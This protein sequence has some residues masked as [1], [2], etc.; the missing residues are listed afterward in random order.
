MALPLN[1]DTITVTGRFVNF[2]GVPIVGQVKFITNQMLIDATADT[3][4]V[5]SIVSV[6]LDGDGEFS[7]VLPVSDDP[8]IRP[9][10]FAYRVEEAFIG[11]RSYEVTLLTSL[12]STVDLADLR[13]P[14]VVTTIY[15]DAV[16]AGNW[17]TLVPRV[18]AAETYINNGV[19]AP[20]NYQNLA[21]RY[22]VYD[23][24]GVFDY[25][26]FDADG[27]LVFTESDVQ[28][29]IDQILG[30]AD[31]TA[32]N[33]ELRDT[34]DLGIVQS[35]TYAAHMLRHGTYDGLASAYSTYADPSTITWAYSEIG[36]L[37]EDLRK[38]M[39]GETTMVNP[40]LSHTITKTDSSYG[41]I[42]LSYDDYDALAAA[43]PDY[44]GPTG[45][46]FTFTY[47]DV[48]DKIR[49]EANRINR[50]MLLGVGG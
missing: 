22:L 28:V 21:L 19:V 14:D 34:T 31:Y 13:P 39:A 40:Y 3:H 6:T 20:Y 49:A 12:G 1:L 9:E 10:L 2:A 46:S 23:N 26:D 25:E 15:E 16:S 27:T 48:A 45:D 30:L 24:L 11:G 37:I 47:Y 5:P 32:N 4:I 38:V 29:I 33:F 44:D 41:G 35:N 50:L 43:Y 36:A 7:V 8:D 42:G 17:N 18:D